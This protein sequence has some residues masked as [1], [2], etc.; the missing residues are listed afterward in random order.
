MNI[1]TRPATARCGLITSRTCREESD[2]PH[3]NAGT[4]RHFGHASGL[5]QLAQ[6]SWRTILIAEDECNGGQHVG[7]PT[8]GGHPDATGTTTNTM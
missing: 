6:G 1:H 8:R 2:T 5:A 3:F 4:V 7:T